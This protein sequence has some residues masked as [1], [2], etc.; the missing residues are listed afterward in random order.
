MSAWINALMAATEGSAKLRKP[1]TCLA[2]VALDDAGLAVEDLMTG[3]TIVTATSL[4][5]RDALQTLL[6]VVLDTRRRIPNGWPEVAIEEAV[7]VVRAPKREAG[8]RQDA[9]DTG[10][11]AVVIVG[12]LSDVHPPQALATADR[13]VALGGRYHPGS[14]EAAIMMVT[15]EHLDLEDSWPPVEYSDAVACLTKGSTAV[16]CASRLH[17][18][19]QGR[20]S[21]DREAEADGKN[22][23][24]RLAGTAAPGQAASGAVRRLAEMTGFGEA[25]HWGLQAACDIR[26]YAEGRLAW[27]EVDRGVLLSGPPGSGKTT[28]ALALALEAGVDLVSTTYSDWHGGSGGDTVA[29]GLSKLFDGWRDKAKKGPF[30]LLIDEIDTVGVRGANAHNESWFSSVINAWLAFLDGAVPREGI[31]VVGATNH[32]E[33]VDPALLRPGRLD[34]HVGM[35]IPDIHALVGVVR[36]HLGPDAVIE[37]AELAR[38]A[39]ACRGMSPAE[40]EQVC[41]EAR[42]TARTVFRRRP[43]AD[44]VSLVLG[45]R[46][47]KA[48]QRPGAADLDR[49]I[50]IHEAGHAIAILSTPGEVLLSVDLD[51]AQPWAERRESMTLSEAEGMLVVLLAGL[52]AEQVL[53]GAHASGA[54]RDLQ[55]ATTMALTCQAQ[56]GMG[57]MGLR[58]AGPERAQE[59]PAVTAA[60]DEILRT[61]HVKAIALV[62]GS[63]EAM[64]RLA[65]QLQADRYL[66]AA[67]V[68]T[69]VNVPRPAPERTRYGDR[70]ARTISRQERHPKP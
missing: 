16:E 60:V 11:P 38:A 17:R 34:R 8:W 67:E 63:R 22:M 13:T 58:V 4:A 50:A 42:R 23:L 41:R 15:G 10:R 66:D 12:E 30:V 36:H 64:L 49:R 31:V 33:R 46:R 39:R 26:A 45:A 3:V 7:V 25:G 69:I 52:A 70:V 59:N 6:L 19:I 51:S 43:C 68:R 53:L 29:K 14:L 57:T 61:A 18:L 48:L 9:S 54:S 44:D 65:G 1:S 56:W 47:L 21:D 28:F 32:P 5:L 20:R 2:A 35:P 40:V 62:E 55:E 27:S 24:V 37:N